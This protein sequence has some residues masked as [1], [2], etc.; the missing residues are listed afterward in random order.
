[1]SV[2]RW[3]ELTLLEAQ[4]SEKAADYSHL[5]QQMGLRIEEVVPRKSL[6]AWFDLTSQWTDGAM[7]QKGEL[8]QVD[9]RVLAFLDEACSE[10]MS[11][12]PQDKRAEFLR[13]L[14]DKKR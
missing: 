14:F 2:P 6:G 11:K 3:F 13:G 9:E 5:G 4:D 8:G 1:M 7:L 10:C 12:I